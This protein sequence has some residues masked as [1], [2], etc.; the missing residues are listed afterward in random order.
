MGLDGLCI[1]GFRRKQITC[2]I[3]KITARRVLESCIID[4]LRTQRVKS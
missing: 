3:R 2:E 1:D 4:F